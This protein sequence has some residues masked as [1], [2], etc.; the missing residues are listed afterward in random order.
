MSSLL[1]TQSSLLITRSSMLNNDSE[2]HGCDSYI[3]A[4]VV[5]Q[6]HIMFE[7]EDE[8]NEDDGIE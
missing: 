2:K 1:I 3:K 5:P 6:A 8:G 7:L 4:L